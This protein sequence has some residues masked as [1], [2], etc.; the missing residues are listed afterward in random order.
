MRSQYRKNTVSAKLGHLQVLNLQN[1]D[2]VCTQRAIDFTVHFWSAELAN[3]ERRD[4][5]PMR[6]KIGNPANATDGFANRANGFEH[7]LFFI[8]SDK[9]KNVDP[10]LLRKNPKF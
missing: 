5:E 10:M 6:T 1:F 8:T 7:V 2:S 3:H 9:R 4:R